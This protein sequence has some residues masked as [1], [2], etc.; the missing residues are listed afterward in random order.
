M[1]EAIIGGALVGALVVAPLGW[2]VWQD[3][4]TEQ[5]LAVRAVVHAALV[6]ALGGESLVA[7]NVRP[8][9]LGRLGR[10]EL[11]VPSDWRFLLEPAWSAVMPHV[12][13]DY[14]LVVRPLA[15]EVGLVLDEPALRRAA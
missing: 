8:P 13:D 10:V 15:A 7:V 9:G 14:E 1:V 12:P 5:A 6:H 4:R 11:T 3:R 2:R